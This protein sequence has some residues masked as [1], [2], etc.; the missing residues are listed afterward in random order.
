[1]ACSSLGRYLHRGRMLMGTEASSFGVG[2]EASHA[3]ERA[4]SMNLTALGRKLDSRVYTAGQLGRVVR[5]DSG[6]KRCSTTCMRS[7]RPLFNIPRG[8]V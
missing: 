2:L 1:M 6:R 3:F 7:A 8:N 4:A 5:T